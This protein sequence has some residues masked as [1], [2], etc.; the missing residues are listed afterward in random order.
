MARQARD[1]VRQVEVLNSE[2]SQYTRITVSLDGAFFDDGSFIGP[3]TTDFFSHV[4]AQLDARQDIVREIELGLKSGKLVDEIL[5][6]Y[7]ALVRE[8]AKHPGRDASPA[9][10]YNFYKQT[11]VTEPLAVKALFSGETERRQALIRYV[12]QRSA[13]VTLRKL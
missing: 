3:N 9:E 11:F 13:W 10:H 12:L 2:L 1:P 6:P 8:Q 4:K 7:E 5:G